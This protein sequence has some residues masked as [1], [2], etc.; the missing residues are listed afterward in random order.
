[1]WNA[2]GQHVMVN[3]ALCGMIG[4]TREELMAMPDLRDIVHTEE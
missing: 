4:L 1:M 2:R 3:E